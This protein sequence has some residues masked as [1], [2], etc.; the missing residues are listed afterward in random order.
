MQYEYFT[1]QFELTR[2]CNQ[3][4]SHCC[5]GES[6]DLDI[7]KETV[8]NFLDK[9]NIVS[10]DNL[11]FSGGEP[12][13]NGEMA[14]Y[15][16]DKLIE[17]DVVIDRFS[18]FVNGLSYSQAL[19]E[20]LD[21]LYRYSLK[22]RRTV[23]AESMLH[24]STSQYHKKAKPEIVAKLEN[25]PYFTGKVGTGYIPDQAL[26]AQGNAKKNGLTLYKTKDKTLIRKNNGFEIRSDAG[27]ISLYFPFQQLSS[28][29]N[30]TN[31]GTLSYEYIDRFPVGNVNEET[32]EEMYKDHKRLIKAKKK[33]F[34]NV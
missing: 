1:L 14:L 18:V 15:I 29:G 34:K 24:L 22:K 5:R 32:I 8:D 16:A 6:Q 25:L 12:T 4:C 11:N 17:K 2:R 10:I 31:N 19:V 7:T 33:Y 3:S 30:L 23:N 20:A 9:N 28:N 21:K 27:K 26:I 13:L